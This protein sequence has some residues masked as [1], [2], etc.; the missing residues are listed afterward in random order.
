MRTA[1]VIVIGLMVLAAFVWLA[2]MLAPNSSRGAA[3]VAFVVA[4]LVISVIDWYIGVFRAG[5]GA[6]EE[7]RIHA[8]IFVIPVLA[9]LAIIWR[10]RS[11]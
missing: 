11:L 9:A 4:W 3:A 7:F 8:V 1:I 5:Y 6:A 2:P 10:S